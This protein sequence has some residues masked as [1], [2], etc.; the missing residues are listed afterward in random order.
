MNH[1]GLSFGKYSSQKFFP[2]LLLLIILNRTGSLHMFVYI[3]CQGYLVDTVT[4]NC[5]QQMYKFDAALTKYYFCSKSVIM[6]YLVASSCRA[7]VP[8]PRNGQVCEI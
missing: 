6:S 3:V 4:K 2:C 5:W 8:Y 7:A 1:V